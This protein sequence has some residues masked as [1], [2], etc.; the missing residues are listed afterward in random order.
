LAHPVHDCMIKSTKGISCLV[1]RYNSLGSFI[2]FFVT[3]K[4][5]TKTVCC[6][7]VTIALHRVSVKMCLL[8]QI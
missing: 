1:I 6:N 3:F 5:M 8:F 2:S 4:Y 7:F